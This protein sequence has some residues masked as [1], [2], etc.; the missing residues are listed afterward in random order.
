MTTTE[1]KDAAE[2][3]F[4]ETQ[5][6]VDNLV[7]DV[8]EASNE[9]E[10]ELNT[11]TRKSP[12]QFPLIID[13]RAQTILSV[14]VGLY[15][16]AC[17]GYFAVVLF[18]SQI[19]YNPQVSLLDHIRDYVIDMIQWVPAIL[20]LLPLVIYDMLRVSQ[21]VLIP[22]E[23]VRQGLEVLATGKVPEPIP[24]SDEEFN[25]ALLAT[26]NEIRDSV[27]AETVASAVESRFLD[28]TFDGA[29]F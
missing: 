19:M 27:V 9:I 22:V 3:S 16:V 13:R 4:Q 26:Y 24:Y 11:T 1:I 29:K 14:R 2:F 6:L 21:R 17:V 18:F 8:R 28:S 7:Q 20:L 23:E 5:N 10:G 25:V 12:F 15:W